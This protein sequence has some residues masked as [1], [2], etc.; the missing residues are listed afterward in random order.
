M[1]NAIKVGAILQSY[2]DEPKY[3]IFSTDSIDILKNEHLIGEA[4]NYQE[5]CKV[6]NAHLKEEGFK[7]SPYWRIVMNE[8]ATMI[9]YGSWSKFMAIVPPLSREDL[10]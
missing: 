7:S 1:N 6:I 10:V 2:A 4:H 9:D 3:K 5:A 8:T